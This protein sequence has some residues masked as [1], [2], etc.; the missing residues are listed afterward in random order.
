[1]QRLSSKF[2]LIIGETKL[3]DKKLIAIQFNSQK[4]F[5]KL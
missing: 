4:I 1:M 5:K 3:V 2:H